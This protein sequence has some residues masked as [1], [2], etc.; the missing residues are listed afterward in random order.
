MSS[1]YS[2]LL[3]LSIRIS[4]SYVL[5]SGFPCSHSALRFVL[6]RD[7][8]TVMLF[9]KNHLPTFLPLCVLVVSSNRA[10]NTSAPSLCGHYSLHRYYELIRLLACSLHR[11]RRNAPCTANTDFRNKQELTGMP[12][13]TILSSPRSQ[14][15]TEPICSRL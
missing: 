15:P 3:T 9:C 11:L 7:V 6:F 13:V 10:I 1:E 8:V 5:L 4:A 2:S 12:R 14:T